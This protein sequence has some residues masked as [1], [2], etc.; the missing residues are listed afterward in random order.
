MDVPS[1]FVPTIKPEYQEEAYSRF[2]K[3]CGAVVPELADRIYSISFTHDG[4]GWTATVGQT[5]RGMRRR[6][7]RRRGKEVERATPLHDPAMVLAIF[8]GYPYM[9][10]TNHRLPASVRS[11]WENPF[12]AGQPDSVTYFSPSAPSDDT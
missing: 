10:V 11:S 5:L 3:W 6:H 2:A 7:V 1:F 4:Q 9:V 8:A 12:M